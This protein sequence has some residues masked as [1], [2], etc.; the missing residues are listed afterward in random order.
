MTD[1]PNQT[2]VSAEMLDHVDKLLERSRALKYMLISGL[3]H[4]EQIEPSWSARTPEEKTLL[5]QLSEDLYLIEE[6]TPYVFCGTHNDLMDLRAA[7]NLAGIRGDHAAFLALC[8]RGPAYQIPGPE[9]ATLRGIGWAGLGFPDAAAEFFWYAWERSGQG[10][11]RARWLLAKAN[12]RRPDEA[13]EAART[14]LYNFYNSS[15]QEICGAVHVLFC[16]ADRLIHSTT[17]PVPDRVVDLCASIVNATERYLAQRPPT[18]PLSS[19]VTG[20]IV[21]TALSFG[22]MGNAAE[23]DALLSRMVAIDP[24]RDM[25]RIAQG[26]LRHTWDIGLDWGA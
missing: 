12:G 13:E 7:M 11:F 9:L 5:E 15:D 8:R 19:A 18:A 21:E 24:D 23:G 26:T 1:T 2:E 25:L 17:G 20:L 14:V 4:R 22:R 10:L 6:R 3:E 16:I